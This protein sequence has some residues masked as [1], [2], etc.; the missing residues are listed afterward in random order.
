MVAGDMARYI[1][2]RIVW[3]LVTLSL[4]VTALFFLMNILMPGDFI[5]VQVGHSAEQRAELVRPTRSRSVAVEQY[6]DWISG[7]SPATWALVH[8]YAGGRCW[9]RVHWPC[10]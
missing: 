3:G 8:R 2:K 4:F 7:C 10:R 5:P 6:W 9:S 1:A